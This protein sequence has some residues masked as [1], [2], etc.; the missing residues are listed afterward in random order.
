LF[1][2]ST[3]NLQALHTFG[4][5]FKLRDRVIINDGVHG[6]RLRTHYIRPAAQVTELHHYFSDVVVYSLDTGA[7]LPRTASLDDLA[8]PW[9]YYLCAIHK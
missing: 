9:L 4:D 6:G 7:P 3:H 1:F 2:F 5:K 8:D